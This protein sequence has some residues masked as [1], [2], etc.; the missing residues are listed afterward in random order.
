[1][2]TS[3][4]VPPTRREDVVDVRHG[5]PVP[6]PYRWLE[7]GDSPEV[8]EWV[9]AQ[10]ALTRTAVDRPERA[11]WHE[12]LVGLMQLPVLQQAE[13]CNDELF[14]FERPAGS[15]QFILTRRSARDAT[16]PTVILVDPATAAADAAVAIDWY[17]PSHDGTLVAVGTSEGGDELSALR[18]VSGLDGSPA[19][20]ASDEIPYTRACSLAWEPDGSGFFYTRYPEGDEYNRT[21]H[22]H[23]LGRDW[24]DDPVVWDDRPDPQAWAHVVL[25]RDGRW[26]VVQVLSGWDH[27][28]VHVLDRTTDTWTTVIAGVDAYT[29]LGFAADG[30]S[31]V[32]LTDLGAP[33]K[34]VVR[35]ALDERLG[36]GQEHWETLVAERDDVI[37]AVAVSAEG[38]VMIT[39]EGGVDTVHRLDADGRPNDGSVVTGLGD[40]VS[41]AGIGSSKTSSDVFLVVDS[42]SSPTTM[43]KLAADGSATPWDEAADASSLTGDLNVRQVEYPSLDGTAVGLFL[44]R[45]N[46][47][48]PGPETPV[49]LDAYGGFAI[50]K[51]PEWQPQIGAWCAAGGMYAIAALRGGG[52]RGEDWHR[53]GFREN[54][55][56]VFD[57][58]AAAGDYLEA[59]G[60]G[61]RDRLAI[62]GRS[63]GGLLIG[64]TITQRPD[65]CRVALCGVPLLDMIRFPQFLIA[66]LWTPEYG[67]PDVEEEFGWLHAYSP[68]HHVVDGT[69]YPATMIYTAEGDSRVDPLHARKMVALLQSASSCQD[70]NPIVLSQEGRAGHGVGKP[71]SKRADE[72]ADALTF[73]GS[74]VG[75]SP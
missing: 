47:V 5:I 17:H 64:A 66:K 51:S 14:C 13:Y 10:N 6:D 53:A 69:C 37:S 60:L 48:T 40:V 62:H 58:F 12:R 36:E 33:R 50:S 30:L 72:Y 75:L 32:G 18:I 65:L 59:V 8:A 52:E 73:A 19:G 39:S 23:E 67:D 43:W 21:V 31:L 16:A 71:V 45:R 68:Y 7:D 56:N 54:K 46:D 24:R 22:F 41:I 34:R 61:S 1:M 15:E 3:P 4:T 57:D 74:H 25:S 27:A 42:Y 44:I 29:E 35:I 11:R 26:L 20:L 63:H 38:L 2:T 9:N 55:Q 49:M 70:T 28:D